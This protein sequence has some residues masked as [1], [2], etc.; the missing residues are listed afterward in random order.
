MSCTSPPGPLTYL[1]HVHFANMMCVVHRPDA[2][3]L[4][5]LP[6]H[7]GN[8]SFHHRQRQ[9]QQQQQHQDSSFEDS[10]EED[11]ATM[12][13]YVTDATHLVDDQHELVLNRKKSMTGKVVH[14]R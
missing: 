8:D 10:H 3:R 5:D 12:Q 2:I 13:S 11:P 4:Q 14:Y 9:Q 1:C 6:M 7:I